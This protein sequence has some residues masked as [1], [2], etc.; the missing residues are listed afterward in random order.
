[1]SRGQ[2]LLEFA[3]VLPVFLTM[4][5]GISVV[6]WL[7]A[8]RGSVANAAQAAARAAIV[9]PSWT[10]PNGS[11]NC[12]GGDIPKAAQQASP[13][14]RINQGQLCDSTSSANTYTQSPVAGEASI[15]VVIGGTPSAPKSFAVTVT[16]Q[17]KPAVILPDETLF[18][19]ST[20]EA[21]Q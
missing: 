17:V 13:I 9:A 15:E 12:A 6:G 10:V 21:Y 16:A 1:M 11:L 4:V 19:H 14:I 7:I 20:V 5:F 2:A 8:Q 3:L 18:G